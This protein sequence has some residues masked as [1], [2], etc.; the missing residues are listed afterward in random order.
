M[1][2]VIISMHDTTLLY[3]IVSLRA[4]AYFIT[5]CFQIRERH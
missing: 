3:R 2:Y 5:V 1:N 4:F